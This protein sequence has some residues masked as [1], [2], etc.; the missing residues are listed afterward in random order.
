MVLLR[1]LYTVAVDTKAEFRIVKE[2]TVESRS[3]AR[4]ALSLGTLL[5]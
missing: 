4:A 2:P 5:E 1:W 3:A